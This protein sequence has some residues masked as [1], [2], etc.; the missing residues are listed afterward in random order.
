MKLHELSPAEGAKSTRK[1]V[2]RGIG[3]GLGK[4]S[5]RGHKGQKA[6]SGGGVRPGFEGGQTP[7][8]R[9][10]PKRGFT[11]APFKKELTEVNVAKLNVFEA[12]TVVT[13]EKLIEAK[14]IKNLKDG[15]KILGQGD[16]N[17]ALTVKAHRFSASAIEKIEAAGGK[18]EVC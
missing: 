14:V 10:L 6:R 13:P 7:L 5:G 9:R 4:T 17:V 18:A 8:F 11:N 3:S 1:R 15:V 2:G 16:L 12:G